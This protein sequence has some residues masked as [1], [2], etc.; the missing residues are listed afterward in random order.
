MM[1][2]FIVHSG[3][4][5]LH[6]SDNQRMM[7]ASGN[8][9]CCVISQRIHSEMANSR[10]EKKGERSESVLSFRADFVQ[11]GWVGAL[12]RLTVP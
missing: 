3:Q 9:L 10:A 2:S 6:L 1:T 8:V 7:T 12:D 11:V 5:L 4:V